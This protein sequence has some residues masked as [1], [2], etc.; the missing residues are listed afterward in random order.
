V[1]LDKVREI[2]KLPVVCNLNF[3]IFSESAVAVCHW[4]WRIY[5]WRRVVV[6]KTLLQTLQQ[7]TRVQ[8]YNLIHLHFN[9]RIGWQAVLQ[10]YVQRCEKYLGIFGWRMSPGGVSQNRR[11]PSTADL[12]VGVRSSAHSKYEAAYARAIGVLE[13]FAALEDDCGA[14]I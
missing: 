12:V 10:I 11:Y 2:R 14:K 4:Q 6:Y 3:S 8:F 13:G 7:I 9:F 5:I 1:V